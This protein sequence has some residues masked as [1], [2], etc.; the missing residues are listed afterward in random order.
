M[1]QFS[2]NIAPSM[3][4]YRATLHQACPSSQ[5]EQHRTNSQL[6]VPVLKPSNTAPS[7]SQFSKR[8]KAHQAYVSIR[9]DRDHF[10]RAILSV[11]SADGISGVLKAL[12]NQKFLGTAATFFNEGL[13]F[14]TTTIRTLKR[15]TAI[16]IC[17]KL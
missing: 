11:E 16:P 5:T 8:A 3:S 9:F 10:P 1:S 15:Y 2:S 17:Y 12:E 14:A 13:V 7:M 6:H 4:Q